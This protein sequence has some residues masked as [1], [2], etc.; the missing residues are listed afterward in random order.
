MADSL[1]T[2]HVKLDADTATFKS[3]LVD[4]K[5]GIAGFAAGAGSMLSAFAGGVV[6]GMLVG[7]IGNA[8]GS[9]KGFITSGAEAADQ[10]GKLAQKAGLPVA[11]VQT[12]WPGAGY[13]PDRVGQNHHAGFDD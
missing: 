9:I 11:P 12:A 6:G 4:A 8:I 2:L 5:E 10:M 13:R 1:G 7:S 3:K